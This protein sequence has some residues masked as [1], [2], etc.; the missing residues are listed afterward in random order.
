MGFSFLGRD[1]AETL[2]SQGHLRLSISGLSDRQ[3]EA[4][5][6]ATPC[7]KSVS[8]LRLDKGGKKFSINRRDDLYASTSL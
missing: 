4:E 8:S 5:I 2:A 1:V 6:Q 7:R 3:E